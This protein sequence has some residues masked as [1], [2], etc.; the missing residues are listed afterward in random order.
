MTKLQVLLAST[1]LVGAAFIGAGHASAQTL[2]SCT[3]T[4]VPSSLPAST[5]ATCVAGGGSTLAAPTYINVF[6]L[7]T[8]NTDPTIGYSLV[9]KGSGPSQCA[10]LTNF[11][12]AFVS[13]SSFGNYA[14]NN[15]PIT[16]VVDYST[17]DAALSAAQIRAWNGAFQTGDSPTCASSDFNNA[18][19]TRT[20]AT[21]GQK[22]LAGNIV[23]LPTIG[24][25]ITVAFNLATGIRTTSNTALQFTDTQLCGIFSGKITSW[26]DPLLAGVATGTRITLP[27]TPI[28][29]IYRSDG[30]GTS[31]LFTSHLHAVCNTSNSNFNPAVFTGATTSFASIFGGTAPSNFFG[32]SG[33]PGVQQGIVHTSSITPAAPSNDAIGY[34]SPDYTQIAT[35]PTSAPASGS[36]PAVTVPP[37]VAEVFNGTTA[38]QPTV[39]NT[40]AA[41]A[42]APAINNPA[43][44]TQYDPLNPTPTAGYP[45]V[46]FTTID[47]AQCY[48]DVNVGYALIGTMSNLYSDPTTLASLAQGGFSP[49]PSTLTSTISAN[50]FNT[51]SLNVDINNPTVCMSNGGA[52]YAGR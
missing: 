19:A 33:S 27:K 2:S 35:R 42:T 1:A 16:P 3:T 34:L 23:Q 17:S 6:P 12:S 11:T 40:T 51:S 22:P 43:D 36:F 38:Y 29:V 15:N 21:A 30:S 8:G 50:I 13:S 26:A 14:A 37:Y 18:A 49:V 41:L 47:L 7:Y 5:A 20:Y 28:T 9:G 32:E 25:P 10:F 45:I 46:G 52:T 4:V 39:G 48:Q 24:T 44:P 31:Y